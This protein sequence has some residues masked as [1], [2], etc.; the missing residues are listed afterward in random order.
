MLIERLGQRPRMPNG[1]LAAY[2]PIVRAGGFVF[3]SGQ[4]PFDANRKI[5]SGG[6]EEQARQCYENVRALLREA[7]CGLEHVVKTVNYLADP[8]DFAAF[9]V[10]Y[11]ELFGE[12]LPARSTV[13][14]RLLV[15]G[16]A[17]EVDVVACCDA[18]PATLPR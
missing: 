3:V 17:I 4:L 13:S 16:A 18:A 6:I 8:R 1:T 2:S 7:G 12:S 10:A 5:V 11:A 15:D 9:N 14:A